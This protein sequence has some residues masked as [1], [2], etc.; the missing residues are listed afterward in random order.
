MYSFWARFEAKVRARFRAKFRDFKRYLERDLEIL[1]E[2]LNKIRL[3]GLLCLFVCV[4]VSDCPCHQS[5]CLCQ[6]VSDW[7]CLCVCIIFSVHV[8]V[9]PCN[10]Y[11][12]G[13]VCV[14]SLWSFISASKMANKWRS[15]L[16]FFLSPPERLTVLV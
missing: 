9:C 10:Y 2:I 3:A 1:S 7:P 16:A 6:P 15:D 12:I 8:S 13:C 5:V 11:L 4:R 14:C